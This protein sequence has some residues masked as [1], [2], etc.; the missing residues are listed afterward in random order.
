[1]RLPP[2]FPKVCRFAGAVFASVMDLALFGF[3]HVFVLDCFSQSFVLHLM[4][5]S[6]IAQ[7]E[8]QSDS[9]LQVALGYLKS[10]FRPITI[11]SWC[12]QQ[13]MGAP[14]S[15]E[16]GEHFALRSCFAS[17]L[18]RVRISFWG[19]VGEDWRP[20]CIRGTSHGRSA[21]G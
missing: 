15:F 7:L 6:D 17:K 10:S 16:Y 19:A 21:T 20:G 4:A 9:G 8:P 14:I 2:C 5:E 11:S 13:C 18:S 1:V 3:I 12:R